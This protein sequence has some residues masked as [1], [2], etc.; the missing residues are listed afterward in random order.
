[1][2]I[3]FDRMIL[4]DGGVRSVRLHLV[5]A[6][7]AAI[8]TDAEGRLHPAIS[9]KRLAIQ[10]GGT[11]LTAKFVDDLAELAGGAA[12]GAGTARIVGGGAAATF[13]LL[14]KG[15]EV[16]LNS[17]DKIEVEF[18]RTVLSPANVLQPIH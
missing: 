1:M 6:A 4:P 12:V 11:A 14:Q 18:D 15:R 3:A 10:L 5:D 13:F 17:G 7:P 2:Y 8:K 16:K 9:K